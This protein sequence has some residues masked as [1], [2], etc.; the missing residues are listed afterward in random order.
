MKYD[1]AKR[2]KDAGFPQ[3]NSVLISR[4]N[5]V[6]ADFEYLSNPDLSY[7]IKMCG[8]NNFKLTAD[9][10]GRWYSY[11]YINAVGAE[12]DTPEEAVAKL[13]IKLNGK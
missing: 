8:D 3:E 6:G 1:L 4:G 11:S 2:L 9:H 12:G 10:K 7:L 5:G 13:W